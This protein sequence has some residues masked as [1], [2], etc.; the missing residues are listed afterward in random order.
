MVSKLLKASLSPKIPKIRHRAKEEVDSKGQCWKQS[1]PRGSSTLPF[2]VV[3]TWLNFSAFSSSIY[4][5]IIA[6]TTKLSVPGR[7][8]IT[9]KACRC[10]RMY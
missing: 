9:D 10:L 7:N 1:R 3:Q 5:S 2:V 4:F 6:A 8:S